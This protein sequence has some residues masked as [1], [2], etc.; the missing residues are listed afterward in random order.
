MSFEL[1][2]MLA[3]FLEIHDIDY[4]PLEVNQ[5]TTRHVN[6]WVEANEN[7]LQGSYKTILSTH[8]EAIGL[9]ANLYQS[10]G[11][12]GEAEQ[13]YERALEGWE[14]K[15]GPK[16]PDMLRTVEG[17]ARLYRSQG[18]YGEAERLYLF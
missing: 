3:M 12:Y 17:L 2:N 1:T 8:K 15:L 4:L 13:L 10:Q 6:A 9:F 7:I 18:R 14:E 5:E 11:L 16:H